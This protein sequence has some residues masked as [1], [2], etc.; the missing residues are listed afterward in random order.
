M[1][2]QKVRQVI[3]DFSVSRIHYQKSSL[4]A[5]NGSDS[6]VERRQPERV[7]DAWDRLMAA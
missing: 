3:E 2:A 5:R 1:I 6:R 7:E 4:T